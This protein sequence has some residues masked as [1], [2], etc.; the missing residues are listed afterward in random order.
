MMRPLER[1]VW[2]IRARDEGE[3]IE[4]FSSNWETSLTNSGQGKIICLYELAN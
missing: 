1:E 3:E 2:P 4:R